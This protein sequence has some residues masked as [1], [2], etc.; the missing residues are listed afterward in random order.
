MG[1]FFFLEVHLYGL[2]LEEYN[3]ILDDTSDSNSYSISEAQ[4]SC[5]EDEEA[6][7]SYDSE[8]GNND[9]SSKISIGSEEDNW[10]NG[11]RDGFIINKLK[12]GKSKIR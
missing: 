10:N 8:L 1:S 3:V 5:D 9:E 2:P 7:I 12:N 6:S 11:F 4:N